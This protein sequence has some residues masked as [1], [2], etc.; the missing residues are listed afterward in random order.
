MK[1]EYKGFE[2]KVWREQALGGWDNLYFYI[3]RISDG[4]FLQDAFTTGSDT[5]RDYIKYMK[6]TV[7]DYLK[8]PKDYE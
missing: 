6:E 3:C 2:I 4:W 5:V 1:V 8:N 7:D